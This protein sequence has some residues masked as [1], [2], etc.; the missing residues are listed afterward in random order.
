M[1]DTTIEAPERGIGDNLPPTP[2][3]ALRSRVTDLCDGCDRTVKALQ[4]VEAEVEIDKQKLKVKVPV[5]PDRETSERAEGFLGQVVAEFKAIEDQRKAD[6][7]PHDDAVKATNA[8][9]APLTARLKIAGAI[10][11]A[12]V[13]KFLVA[14]RARLDEEKRK[15]AAAAAETQR[16]AQEAAR[17]AQANPTVDNIV[18]AQQAGEAAGAAIERRDEAVAAKPQVRSEFSTRARTL[19]EVRRAEVVDIDECFKHYRSHPDVLAC[20]T[21]LASADARK[22]DGPAAI[23]GA[24]I[25][26]ESSLT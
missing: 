21:M 18:A 4:T 13:A 25:I 15:A 10:M 26:V 17:K 8:M 22:K 16:Q 14:E 7:A 19:R 3:D 9:Y 6:N 1:T 11:R 24:K 2:L 5:L 12:A 20:L 23:P